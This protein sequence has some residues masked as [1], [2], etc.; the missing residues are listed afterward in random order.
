MT[1]IECAA[2]S[3]PPTL[4][5]YLVPAGIIAF[6]AALYF[7]IA[8]LCFAKAAKRGKKSVADAMIASHAF[9]RYRDELKKLRREP[10]VL[11]ITNDPK[12]PKVTLHIQYR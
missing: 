12:K 4:T 2:I 1:I 6:L 10:R 8:Y 11:M 9:D 7:F 5:Q 3:S